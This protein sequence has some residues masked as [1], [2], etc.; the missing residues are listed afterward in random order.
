VALIDFSMVFLAIQLEPSHGRSLILTASNLSGRTREDVGLSSQVKREITKGR[1]T[2]EDKFVEDWPYFG[3]PPG[4][5]ARMVFAV[6]VVALVGLALSI[7][8]AFINGRICMGVFLV[9]LT[10]LV[11]ILPAF[12]LVG[13]RI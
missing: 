9:F 4:K 11:G 5:N 7:L 3:G 2:K 12:F 13:S 6:W 1:R 8:Y 10:A